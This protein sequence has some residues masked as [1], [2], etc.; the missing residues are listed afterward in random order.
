M[1]EESAVT[2]GEIMTRDVAVVHPES[3]LLDAVKLMASR[4]VSGLPVVDQAAKLVGIITEGD[5][6]RWHEG[7]SER[8][9]RWL[10]MLA[11]GL[12]PASAF[13]E[14][15]RAEHN[16][17]KAVMSG[18]VTTVTEETPARQIAALM[19]DKDIK[20]VPV[21]R[22]GRL[23]GIVARSDLIRA[24]AEKLQGRKSSTAEPAT[25]LNE[26]LRRGREEAA[27]KRAQSQ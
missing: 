7:S 20:R 9:Q 25:S 12:Q 18:K 15:I 11:E 3:S 23:V 1:L 2:A 26:A 14:A 19:H 21:M 22:D 27:A 17:V 10:D 4:R 6:V 13:V 16:R 8:E 5:L 24:L